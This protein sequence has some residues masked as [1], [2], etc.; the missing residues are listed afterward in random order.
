MKKL[1]LLGLSFIMILRL[2]GQTQG[3]SYQA[4]IIDKTPQEIPGRDI[5]G[6]IIPNRQ[7]MMRFSILDA[8]G[9]IEYQ[10]EHS[11]STD[12]YGM[13]ALVIGKG[14]RTS[15]SPNPFDGI[16]WNGTPKSLKIDLSLSN[17]EIF[18]T[19][20]SIEELTFVPYAYHKNI[21]ATGSL[22]V[23]GMTSLNSRVD[24]TDGSPTFLTGDLTVDKAT[25]LHDNLTVNAASS[26]K[27]QVTINPD[28]E[29]PGDK[30]SY[31]SYPLRVEGGN[32]GIAVRIDGSRTS[33]NYFLT[34]WDEE[35]IQGRIEGQTT[36]DLLTD[37][38]YI[39]DN[40][41]F[42]NE[43][44]RSTVDVVKAV[45]GVASASS[46]ST[47][48]AG[49]GACVTA[50]V[51]SLIAGAVAEVVMESANLALVVA[52]PVMY[53]VFKHTNIGVSYQSGAGDYA[54]WLP[55]ADKKEKFIPG[56]IVG[57]RG[58]YISRNT[59]NADHY[60]VISRNPIVL[61][62]MP[63]EGKEAD[64]EKVAFLGQVP[65]KVFGKVQSGDYILPGGNNNG[66]GTGV[67]PEKIQPDQYNKIV[68]TAWSGSESNEYGYVNVVTGLNAGQV[69][70]LGEKQEKIIKDQEAE[71][72]SLKTQINKM[73]D[74]L[75]QL[76]PGFSSLMQ[77]DQKK[78]E[79]ATLTTPVAQAAVAEERT[80]VYHNI[81]R[82]QIL[83]GLGLAEKILKEKGVDIKSHPFFMKM[84]TESGYKECFVNDVLTSVKN[85]MEKNYQEDIKTGTR[86]IKVQ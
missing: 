14:T 49:L 54:E 26:L 3:I 16:D 72:K 48:C 67:S 68:G 66:A 46:S 73:N 69:A 85:E 12:M 21:T 24:V 58:G 59:E 37:P 52:E 50:P 77:Q 80:V 78:G 10:E 71:I 75:A 83:E 81:T 15:L 20:F 27:G 62:N 34:F 25:T 38:E 4:V 2:F 32:Q 79:S 30:S 55:K 47:V 43:V 63:E 6:N 29:T 7:I 42:A 56:D 64:Y 45:A 22:A 86:V 9:T 8:A 33:N 84:E 70:K 1:I 31:E 74:A 23:D 76:L 19:D 35:N 5:T 65:V 40:I 36:T 18:Y 13:I 60:M 61:G 82:E 39:F 57:V 41:L 17:E 53:N 51:P 44:I 11:T 28:F